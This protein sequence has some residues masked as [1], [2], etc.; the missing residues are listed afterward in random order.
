MRSRKNCAGNKIHIGA[1]SAVLLVAAAF[2]PYCISAVGDG[3]DE[4][5]PIELY[6]SPEGS[7]EGSGT[8]DEPLA[9][10]SA[11]RDML[12]GLKE[13]NVSAAGAVVYLREGVYLQNDTLEFGSEDSGSKDFPI[14]YKAYN[15]ETAVIDGGIT[16]LSEDFKKPSSDDP[17]VSRIKDQD[18]RKGVVVYDLKA[19]GIDYSS[20]SFAVFYDGERGTLARYPNEQ[21]ILGFHDLSDEHRGDDRYMYNSLDGTFYDKE[22]VVSGWESIDG[23][24]ICGM[25]EIDWA[26]SAPAEIVSYDAVS[27]RV[28]VNAAVNGYSGRYYYSNVIEEIDTV[29][30]YYIDKENGILYFYAP[31]NYLDIKI[32]VPNVEKLISIYSA[33][34]ITLDGIVIENSSGA[35]VDIKADDVTI[36]NCVIRCGYYGVY[37]DGY[38]NRILNNQIYRIGSTAVDLHG[39]DMANLLPSDSVLSNNSI[40]DFGDV[41]RVYAGAIYA[42]G[43]GFEISHNEI[44]HAPHTAM[45]NLAMEMVVEYN[46]FH[47]LCYEG[48]DAGAIY[49]GTWRGNGNVFSNNVIANI[50]N[51]TSVYYTPNGYYCDDGGGGKTF[52]SNI[53]VNIDGDAIFFGG[54]PSNIVTDNIIVNSGIRYDQRAYYPGTGVNAGWTLT[55]RFDADL[56]SS[57]LNWKWMINGMDAYASE[58]WALR[59]PWTMLLK[60]TNVVD[61]NDNFVSYAFLTARI[62]NNVIA[63]IGI[64]DIQNNTD[65]LAV[66]RDNISGLSTDKIFADYEGGDYTVLQDSAIYHA[67]PGFRACDFSKVGIQE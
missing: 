19:A 3:I 14:T 20:D 15:G 50:T 56:M 52:T 45:Q 37:S 55:G 26:Q 38:R 29:G 10:V 66:V 23:V 22:N 63:G 13:D 62:R 65:R 41:R 64:N 43:I 33:E 4:I 7:D 54:G 12:L 36:K 67:L 39:G 49:D 35:L 5:V 60:T 32:S 31:E 8:I 57:G 61:L 44:Y 47:D 16:L 40:H 6:V 2:P 1:L 48:G 21:Y 30:E 53:C 11:A 17:Y 25:F 42:E 9:T 18:A 27:N 24:K 58:A 59:F 46:Y 28:K 34:N 51:P